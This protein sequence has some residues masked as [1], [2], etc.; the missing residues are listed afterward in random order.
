MRFALEGE[1][2]RR[3]MGALAALAQKEKQ[4]KKFLALSG[5]MRRHM[6][7][8]HVNGELLDTCGTGGD[9]ANTFNVSTLAALICAVAGE[10]V[11]KHGNRASSSRCRSFDLLEQ[12]GAY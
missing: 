12:L 9:G 4:R 2:V 1:G 8:I 7:K 11:A 10:C 3:Q 6:I 5:P